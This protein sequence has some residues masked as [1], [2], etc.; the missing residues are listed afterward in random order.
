M[1]I[2]I[3]SDVHANIEALT[4][5]EAAERP[6]DRVFCNGDIVDYG[7]SP[8]ECIE[9]L[10]DWRADV[11]RGNHDNAVGARVDCGCVGPF[12]RLSEATRQLMWT[13]LDE[14]EQKWLA[15][16]PITRTH[17]VDGV[18]FY[19]CHATPRRIS[20]YIT[21]ETTE[22]EWL[23][24]FQDVAADIVLLGHTHLQIERQLDG[25]RFVNPGSAGQAKPRG[26]IAQYAVWQDGAVYLKSVPYDY[27]KTQAKLRSLPLEP[28]ITE[29]LCWVLEYGGL[30]GY[31]RSPRI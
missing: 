19:Q 1:K 14:R 15:E 3:L 23:E 29:E 30:H 7:P 18:S 26:S 13:L 8:N 27:E 31:R 5:I 4:A 24:L 6:F 22:S 2:L 28:Q 20:E 9:W 16:L 17:L 12:R 21:R 10:K 11:V 25:R